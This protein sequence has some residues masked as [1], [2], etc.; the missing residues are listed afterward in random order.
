MVAPGDSE[1]RIG[2]LSPGRRWMQAALAPKGRRRRGC[3]EDDARTDQNRVDLREPARG[4]GQCG[5]ARGG[6]AALGPRRRRVALSRARRIAPF[7]SGSRPRRPAARRAETERR[8]RARRRH[9]VFDARICRVVAGQLQ[10]SARLDHRLW[11]P[12]SPSR[13]VDQ[14][15]PPWRRALRLVLDKAGAN[16]V[17]AA[18]ADIPVCRNELDSKGEIGDEAL[19]RDIAAVTSA[20]ALAARESHLKREE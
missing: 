20:L 16:V 17:E 7:Q 18:C 3:G 9:P 15:I 4:L 10:K 1:N 6:G 2:L 13:G 5:R 14:S 8:P 11:Q 19:L 12:L